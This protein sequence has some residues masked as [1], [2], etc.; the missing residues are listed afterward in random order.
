[1][2]EEV[3]CN[4]QLRGYQ[5]QWVKDIFS[6]WSSGNRRVLAQLATGGGKTI[7]FAHISN[8]FFK[9]DKQVLVIAHRLELIAQAGEK[10]EQIVS[11]PV[12]IIKSGIP[13]HPERKIQAAS[14]Q[15]LARRELHAHHQSRN[16]QT[17]IQR[18]YAP[19]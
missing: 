17:H 13:S 12:G 9:R 18:H 10:L 6:S 14:I 11:E 15:S 19:L 7:C 16:R 5:Q 1:M 3:A 2:T 8:R 4:Y